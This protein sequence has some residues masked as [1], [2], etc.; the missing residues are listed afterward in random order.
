[1]YS[2]MGNTGCPDPIMF[3]DPDG[4]CWCPPPFEDR[5]GKCINVLTD[6]P[7]SPSRPAPCPDPIM[8]RALDGK[9][10]CPPPYLEQGGRCVNA[11]QQPSVPS[12]GGGGGGGSVQ[13]KPKT[14]GLGNVGLIALAAGGIALLYMAGQKKGQRRR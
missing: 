4:K 5:G 14:A 3:K 12:G 10:W 7:H 13:P 9:C 6:K 1:M 2:A 11:L 8:F